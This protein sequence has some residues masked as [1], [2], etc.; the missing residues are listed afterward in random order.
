MVESLFPSSANLLDSLPPC[1]NFLFN[2]SCSVLCRDFTS[3]PKA[4]VLLGLTRDMLIMGNRLPQ[5]DKNAHDK[6]GS[7]C[8]SNRDRDSNANS[9]PSSS[10]SAAAAAAAPKVDR[11]KEEAAEEEEEVALNTCTSE[12]L[13]ELLRFMKR[14]YWPFAWDTNVGSYAEGGNGSQGGFR[15]L[16]VG[17]Q[18]GCWFHGGEPW[19][20]CS[21]CSHRTCS[22][23]QGGFTVHTVAGRWT[24]GLECDLLK[25]KRLLEIRSCRTYLG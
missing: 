10:S 2:T 17:W 18:A 5:D 16:L 19:D 25:R 4:V 20:L 7:S 24:A 22:C 15:W 9:A 21:G 11:R 1:I 8:S 3:P 13:A 14:A 12:A 6:H 23:S